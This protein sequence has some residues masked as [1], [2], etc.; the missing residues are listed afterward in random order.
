MA[1]TIGSHGPKTMEAIRKA[2][3]KLIYEHGFEAMSLRQLASEVGIQVGSLYNHITTKQDL[4]YDLIKVHMEELFQQFD[5]AMAAV[6]TQGPVGRLKAFIA[7]HVTYHILRKREV[8][9]GASEL[10]SLAPEHYEEIVALRRRYERHLIEILRQGEAQGL[11]RCGDASV[12]AY[13]ILA[14]LTGVCTWFRPHGRLS[15]E[16]V[17]ETYSDLVLQGLM[18]PPEA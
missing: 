13:G 3:L 16:Q 15:K 12:A 2:G 1:R 10:R 14:M 11:F 9:I 4:L 6:E 8:F 7:F 18:L 17:A 5:A